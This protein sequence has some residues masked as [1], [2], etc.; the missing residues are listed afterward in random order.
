MV[1]RKLEIKS[2]IE[3][4]I[5]R[6]VN[7]IDKVRVKMKIRSAGLQDSTIRYDTIRCTIH[8]Q[9]SVH[10]NSTQQYSAIQY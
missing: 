8:H 1:N 3:N 5:E 6:S 7:D 10:L 2:I 9:H 4:S